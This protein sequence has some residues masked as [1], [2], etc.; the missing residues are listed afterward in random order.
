ML[1]AIQVVNKQY[2]LSDFVIVKAVNL[3][4]ST[5]YGLVRKFRKF[6]DVNFIHFLR[7]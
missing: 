6:I 7:Q 4:F 3:I 2:Y 1:V 5:F